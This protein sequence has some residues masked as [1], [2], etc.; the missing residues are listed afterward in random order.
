MQSVEKSILIY[1]AKATPRLLYICDLLFKELLGLDFEI[2]TD[3]ETFLRE[4]HAKIN[5]SREQFSDEFF[6]SAS[7][8]LFEQHIIPQQI[9]V[10]DWN[11]CKV[12]FL[13]E[14]KAALPYDPLAAA[15][16]LVSRYEE[17]LPFTT[18]NYG[19]FRA[20]ESLAFKENFLQM[21]VVN[22]FA[23]HLKE[24]LS[25]RFPHLKIKENKFRFLLTYDID[26]AYAYREKGFLRTTG[27]I[28]KSL[29]KG[30]IKLIR[31]RISVLQN[32]KSDP[33]DTFDLAI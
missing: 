26:Q 1:S 19:R 2:T 3:K 8:L 11:G 5:Y 17:Y 12:F 14:K 30:N 13:S 7:A 18:D 29:L 16:Y 32:K 27:S 23:W 33:F 4:P 21:P 28:F 22:H 15:F 9:K 20:E 25:Q 24:C 6:I 31:E 10:K